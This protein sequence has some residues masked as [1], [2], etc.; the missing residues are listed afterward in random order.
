MRY[1]ST[2][3]ATLEVEDTRCEEDLV[4]IK[5]EDECFVVEGMWVCFG[6]RVIGI[7]VDGI[8][9]YLPRE[10]AVGK[11]RLNQCNDD[12]ARNEDAPT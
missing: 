9:S 2:Y 4:V 12:T 10:D 1:E 11:T 3:G 8:H 6:D 5:L 7:K